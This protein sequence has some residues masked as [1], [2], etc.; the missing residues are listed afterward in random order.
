MAGCPHNLVSVDAVFLDQ[1]VD[2]HVFQHLVLTGGILALQQPPPSVVLVGHFGEQ[3]SPCYN[4]SFLVL[5]IGRFG[6]HRVQIEEMSV[7]VRHAGVEVSLAPVAVIDGLEVVVHMQLH[8]GRTAQGERVPLL[9][10][11]VPAQ[12][13]HDT[14]GKDLSYGGLQ[15]DGSQ[16]L[17]RLHLEH[18]AAFHIDIADGTVVTVFTDTARFI[19]A[20]LPGPVGASDQLHLVGKRI[21][22]L[23]GTAYGIGDRL[24]QLSHVLDVKQGEIIPFPAIFQQGCILQMAEQDL[25]LSDLCAVASFFHCENFLELFVVPEPIVQHRLKG[26]GVNDWVI[27]K[28]R[29]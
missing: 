11:H 23:A 27:S 4:L 14:R 3:D 28:W 7:L 6:L 10:E 15:H 5:E 17:G 16:E 13:V 1:L 2:Q 8:I 29:N 21:I 19:R 12:P 20:V 25:V 9:G 18:P 22:S 24:L 26:C